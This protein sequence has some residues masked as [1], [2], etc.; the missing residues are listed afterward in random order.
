MTIAVVV[1][2]AVAVLMLKRE[3]AKPRKNKKWDI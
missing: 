2:A 1:V 3:S